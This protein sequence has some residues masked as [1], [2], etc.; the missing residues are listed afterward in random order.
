MLQVAVEQR[1]VYIFYVRSVEGTLTVKGRSFEEKKLFAR[2]EKEKV[3]EKT[4]TLVPTDQNFLKGYRKLEVSLDE[5]TTRSVQL[6]PEVA[7][8]H[9][10][11]LF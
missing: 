5:I 10:F 9:A 2:I 11:S 6:S 7:C 3:K 4:K 8:D 1:E